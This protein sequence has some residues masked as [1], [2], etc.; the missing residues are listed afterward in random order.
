MKKH[1]APIIA[2]IALLMRMMYVGGYLALVQPPICLVVT[3]SG[4]A[5]IYVVA[6]YRLGGEQARRFFWRLEQIDRKVRP[7]AWEEP[8]NLSHYE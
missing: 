8:G 2:V 7:G 1:A 3:S 5:G 6:H 4:N